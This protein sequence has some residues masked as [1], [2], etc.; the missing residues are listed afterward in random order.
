MI[1]FDMLATLP[2]AQ[3][4]GFHPFGNLPGPCSLSAS[5]VFALSYQPSPLC[6]LR[7]EISGF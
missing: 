2:G 4:D 1:D 5:I 7:L 3:N 6:D